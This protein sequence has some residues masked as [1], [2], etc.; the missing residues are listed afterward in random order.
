MISNCWLYAVA[1][2]SAGPHGYVL[3][4][5][6]RHSRMQWAAP[7]YHVTRLVRAGEVVGPGFTYDPQT[8][9][10]TAPPEPEE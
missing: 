7:P 5:L 10:F 4:R 3:A 8:D 2:F 9:S 1:Q 6:T